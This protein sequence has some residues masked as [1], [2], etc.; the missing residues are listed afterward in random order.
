M[1]PPPLRWRFAARLM[2]AVGLARYPSAWGRVWQIWWTPPVAYE[3]RFADDVKG[4][5]ETF[6][7]RF[8]TPAA[9]T[10]RPAAAP[11]LAR[12]RM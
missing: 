12:F 7:I 6:S 8:K 5:C 9:R 10:Q 4:H 2:L 1:Q 3:V 11:A